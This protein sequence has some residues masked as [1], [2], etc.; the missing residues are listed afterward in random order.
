MSNQTCRE[1][2]YFW[3]GLIREHHIKS[4]ALY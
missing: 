2:Y 1:H 4:A 3:S